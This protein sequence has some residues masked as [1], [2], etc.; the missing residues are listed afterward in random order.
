MNSELIG[1]WEDDDFEDTVAAAL[2]S[3]YE[4]KLINRKKNEKPSWLDDLAI[5]KLRK[6]GP[7]IPSSQRYIAEYEYGKDQ[8]IDPVNDVLKSKF[9]VAWRTDPSHI[10][11]GDFNGY[12]NIF[13]FEEVAS[14]PKPFK[15]RGGGGM[16]RMSMVFPTNDGVDGEKRFL[17]VD[18]SGLIKACELCITSSHYSTR[19]KKYSQYEI[20]PDV[21]HKT[22]FIASVAMQFHADRRHCWA[23]EAKEDVAKA[24]LGCAKEEIKSLLY[25]RSLPM[26]STGRKRPILHLVESHKRRL[27]NGI[28]IDVTSFLRG[29]Q[30]VD[31]GGT[32]FIVRPP[33]TLVD[34][35]SE[36][37]KRFFGSVN[38]G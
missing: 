25:A 20:E 18:K 10:K 22:E 36:A 30:T 17:S 13:L 28:D 34:S 1:L 4:T 12:I 9:C 35:V 3:C 21:L 32:R 6:L 14:L 24:T 19:G 38:N 23:I 37:S 7:F 29:V 26:T 8:Y 5:E 16:F 31:I 11:D 2:I 15:R 33:E 27:R